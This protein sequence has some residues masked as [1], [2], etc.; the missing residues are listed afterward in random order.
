[1][2][3]ADEKTT[4]TQIL[5][6]QIGHGRGTSKIKR[7]KSE[8][9]AK[10]TYRNGGASASSGVRLRR[11]AL[12]GVTWL[13]A[14]RTLHNVT[15]NFCSVNWYNG[16]CRCFLGGKSGKKRVQFMIIINHR[17]HIKQLAL[18]LTFKSYKN[19]TSTDKNHQK[20]AIIK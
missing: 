7:K 4:A 12:A 18:K 3:N 15:V 17:T 8:F 1:M 9:L 5:L 19:K 6:A 16:L 13:F 14:P 11:S 20:Q 2:H 10:R